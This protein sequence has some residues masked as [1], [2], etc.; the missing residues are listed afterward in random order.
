[1]SR[2]DDRRDPVRSP[3]EWLFT[4]CLML[5]GCAIV[6]NLAVALLARIWPW[7]VLLGLIGGGIALA[8]F[9]RSERRR[10]W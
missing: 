5:L 6:L 9:L 8:V 2:H 4:A 10:R 3:I 7:I 1:M